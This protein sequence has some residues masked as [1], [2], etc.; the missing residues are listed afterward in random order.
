M[1]VGLIHNLKLDQ[2]HPVYFREN[3]APSSDGT[4][5]AQRYKSGGHQTTG[6]NTREEGLEAAEKL[7]VAIEDQSIGPVSLA[8]EK[9]FPWDGEDIP[10]MVVWF[11]VDGK[12][13]TP[14]F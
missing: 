6:F 14:I 5:L 1:I 3:P 2:W 12:T 10:A 4:E 8:L 7:A 13:S 9:D 11:V